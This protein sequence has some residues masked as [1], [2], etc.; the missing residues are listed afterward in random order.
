MGTFQVTL[1]ADGGGWLVIAEYTGGGETMPR[2]AEGP[3]AL[4]VQQL[5]VLDGDARGY[6]AALG[7][8]LFAGRVREAFADALD[9]GD[10]ERLRLLLFVEAPELQP[11]RW[12]RLCAPFDG[13]WQPL[14]LSQRAP[15]SRYLPSLTDRRFP[16]LA[17]GDLRAL[18]IAASP[19]GLR[20]F[21][22][23]PFDEAAALAGVRETLGAV[24]HSVLCTAGGDGPPTLD[25][26]CR[27][28]TEGHYP[29]VH[30]VC[31][32]R[33]LPDGES[34]I[35]LARSGDP[36]EVDP[37]TATR[38]IERLA[39]IQGP[40]GLPQ[41]AFLAACESAI[42]AAAGSM[43]GMAQRLV[44]D[45]GLPA[46]VAMSDK[47]SVET[48][49]ALSAAAYS[50][51]LAHGEPDLALAEAT[52]ALGERADITVPGLWSRLGGRPL[53]REL[54]A[55]PLAPDEIARGLAR[56]AGHLA[57]RAPVLVP[58]LERAA[59]A[60]AIANP[61]LL[62]PEARAA[63]AEALD[64]VETICTEAADVS[65][66]ALAQGQEPPPYDARCPFPGLAPFREDDQA[67]F[68][69]REGKVRE[70]G[71]WLDAHAFLAVLG[72]SGSGKSSLV[73]AG[74]IPALR[75]ARP[76]LRVAKITPGELPLAN[77]E[78]AIYE[79]ELAFA[80]DCGAAAEGAAG[81]A[82]EI[83]VLVDQL[84]ELFTLCQSEEERQSFVDALVQLP[85]KCRTVVAM[86][87][88]F[89]GECGRYPGLNTLVSDNLDQIGP[90]TPEELR[91]SMERQAAAVG[92]RFEAGLSG[93]I[94]DDVRGEP[95]AMPL[96]QHA[97]HELWQ[98]RRGR[99]L[100]AEEY[101]AI[102]GIQQAIA[103]TADA[104][105]EASSREERAFMRDIFVRLTRLD[106]SGEEEQRRD[107]RQRV[108]L[109]E[110]VPAGG[111]EA[112]VR[113]LVSRLAT[114][115]LVVVNAVAVGTEH[116]LVEVAHE[117]LIR[118]WPRLR[119]WLSEDRAALLLLAAV[120]RRA[121]DWTQRGQDA[122]SLLRGR[123]L[124]DALAL[125][126][127]SRFALNSMEQRYIEESAAQREREERARE[128]QQQRELAQA[129]ALV[130]ERE[131]SLHKLAASESRQRRL[132]RY[133]LVGVAITGLALLG[134]LYFFMQAATQQAIAESRAADAARE[135]RTADAERLVAVQ[136]RAIAETAVADTERERLA[137]Q[138]ASRQAAVAAAQAEQRALVAR[139]ESAMGEGNTERAVALARSALRI[140]SADPVSQRLLAQAATAP[141]ARL[142]LRGHL[143][144]V[145][146][147]ALHPNT[148]VAV[149]G[150]EDG[151]VIL[152]NL[153]ERTVMLRYGAQ[154][155]SAVFSVAFPPRG[156]VVAAGR[157]DGSITIY[158]LGPSRTLAR[159]GSG[160]VHGL[161]YSPSGLI[162]Y[163]AS[164]PATP[165]GDGAMTIW[166]LETGSPFA[167]FTLPGVGATSV[168][169][170]PDGSL[171][172]AGAGDGT[173]RLWDVAAR[174]ELAVLGADY[175]AGGHSRAVASVAFSADG[176]QLY[177]GSEDQSIGVWDVT[178]LGSTPAAFLR[179]HTGGVLGLAV[180]TI[181]S[182]LLSVSWD[183]TLRM[184]NLEDAVELRRFIGHTSRVRGVA[185]SA[186]GERAVTAGDDGAVRLWDLNDN[187]QS[188]RYQSFDE[189]RAI[190][191]VDAG[192]AYLTT[193]RDGRVV[194][195]S[196]DDGA[197]RNLFP[198]RP[199][200]AAP[201]AVS[202]DGALAATVAE[203]NRI[204]VWD[205]TTRREA[206]S[207]GGG[208]ATITA[209]AFA[210]DGVHLAAGTSDGTVR[211]WDVA[212]GVVV[213]G[214]SLR[215][216]AVSG[217]AFA[218]GGKRV[219]VASYD[220]V[221]RLW[222]P[223]GDQIV[224][225]FRLHDGQILSLA[226][227]SDGRTVATG[228]LD[229]SIWLW[230]AET[231]KRVAAGELAGHTGG[232]LGLAFAPDGKWLA[233]ASYDGT[234][235]LW[236]VVGGQE[237]RRF[238]G[239]TGAVTAVA[240][241]P[242]GRTLLSSGADGSIRRWHV[243][244]VDELERWV[245]KNR[246]VPTLDDQ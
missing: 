241:A 15:F 44:R 153:N 82:A 100:R 139:A 24:P 237:L 72:P 136:Q 183:G 201:L 39:A 37:V 236:D 124:D 98:R 32:G 67:F 156:D 111:D 170:S 198:P 159:P 141:G 128:E 246:Y 155:D 35:Y 223:E 212:R 75:A 230:S 65:F 173:V 60:L 103:H 94:L 95:G 78:R 92:L 219:V 207:L 181:N 214:R 192:R 184:W 151:T 89:L 38:L 245:E 154:G 174:Q 56:L 137:A 70:L 59:P 142:L 244:T 130:E 178:G 146:A 93:V 27:R 191:V 205:P 115:R 21:G 96:L 120:G 42:P 190:A 46:V 81:P 117:A 206:A 218:M 1:R 242:D 231:G 200:E 63:Y 221:A 106:Q 210:P 199:G 104:I 234:V 215:G 31:H 164:G 171:V 34:V 77:L 135:A 48:A 26:I 216:A 55:R 12:E 186:D 126:R 40:R 22:L 86:R 157:A 43:G 6:G 224:A 222:E 87:S 143:G 163:A 175:G 176:A 243:D 79:Q 150:G 99:W 195:W 23:G 179:G 28:L 54:A 187:S 105:Y 189:A 233:S 33:A 47:I 68:Y 80:A 182:R 213:A 167:T 140:D 62:G 204:S 64:Q 110:L 169:L 211:I 240:V 107:T 197:R 69:G 14:A 51:L 49:N 90:M 131:R 149:T 3:L 97:L 112:A 203:N 238:N 232:V 129:N 162:L 11:L 220:G 202:P 36:T 10:G 109:K 180:D 102:G 9:E 226:V 138:L 125:A 4:D 208:G 161:R 193:E 30:L 229:R 217:V 61:E 145:N 225:E 196:A 152:W 158:G 144:G 45:L 239:H 177:S 57:Q 166:N 74:L 118:S 228:S 227:S 122:D 19:A 132:T 50:Q 13:G 148:P 119:G 185:V 165:G 58:D 7:Q 147:V 66:T 20:G 88:D 17:R 53:F 52:A 16:P 29:L 85:A 172:A 18:L 160:P 168:A 73:H 71:A 188:E 8:G 41:F 108:A 25:E 133:L 134:A 101:R 91:A 76:G 113:A 5:Q 194:L 123:E 209:L 83:V 127:Q 235:R 2:R 121:H 114:D 84:E 116:D